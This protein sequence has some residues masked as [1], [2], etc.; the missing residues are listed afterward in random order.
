[1]VKKKHRHTKVGHHSKIYKSP[2]QTKRDLE[3]FARGVERLKELESE[4]NH[5]DTR[6]Y[7]KRYSSY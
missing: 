6:G 2:L 3:L 5:L 1:M 7:S 4:L